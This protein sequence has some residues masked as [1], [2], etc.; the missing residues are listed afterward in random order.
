V[1]NLTLGYQPMSDAGERLVQ[2]GTSRLRRVHAVSPAAE[3]GGIRHPI[4]V[5]ERRRR[6][7]PGAVL[8]KAPP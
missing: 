7:F 1:I 2:K 6:L 5:L 4:G 3:G 8:L